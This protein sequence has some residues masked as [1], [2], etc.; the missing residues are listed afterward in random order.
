MK[1]AILVC[2]LEKGA[3]HAEAFPRCEQ[4]LAEAQIVRKARTVEVGKKAVA[5]VTIAVITQNGGGAQVVKQFNVK[6]EAA[7]EAVVAKAAKEAKAKVETK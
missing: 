1:S 3:L 4:A 7:R 5:V 6:A 2:E